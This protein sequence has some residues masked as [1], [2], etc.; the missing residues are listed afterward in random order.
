MGIV[1]NMLLF[2]GKYFAG[3]LSGSIAITADAFNNLSDAG[4]SIVTL[5]GFKLAAKKPDPDHPFGHGRIEYITGFIVSLLILLM[6]FEIAKSSVEKIFN[7]QN[8]QISLLSITILVVSIL[9][10]LYMAIYN[11]SIGKKINSAA[12]AAT[13]SDSLSDCIA[14][15][16][17]L[18]SMIVFWFTHL[19]ID[20]Y[21]GI[22][23]SIFIFR[24]G[25]TAA[26]ETISPLLGQP[27]EP[28]FVKS[29]ED[30]VMAHE[31]IIGIHDLIVHDYGPGRV[32]ISLHG[33][34][35]GDGNIYKLHDAIDN[36]EN[37]LNE[38]LNCLAVI[39]M[40]PVDVNN[41]K[42]NEYKG[43]VKGIINKFDSNIS[44]HDFRMVSGP[45]H[46]NVIFDI[47]VPFDYKLSDNEVKSK[48][49]ELI[50]EFDPAC[51]AVITVD[52]SY[53][54]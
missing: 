18:L 24:A 6:G 30:I 27:P 44:M 38:K 19:N 22:L 49:S 10:K 39:H 21:C 13:A 4:S 33:E 15:A 14:T 12:M 9:I 3:I 25:I 32:M 26:K 7:P 41:E 2:A 40:D 23:V 46:T 52:K 48:I 8:T 28:E 34:V 11:K 31:E 35:S 47:V 54:K 37:E 53:V 16:V 36:I 1:L 51:F 43:K 29:I 45:T 50:L 42:V 5:A 20:G 17:V